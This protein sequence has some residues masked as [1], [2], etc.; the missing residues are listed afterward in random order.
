MEIV[1]DSLASGFASKNFSINW[2][3]WNLHNLPK[4]SEKPTESPQDYV[5]VQVS[6]PLPK[7]KKWHFEIQK[8][9]QLQNH[10]YHPLFNLLTISASKPFN[11]PHLVTLLTIYP[12]SSPPFKR[13][14]NKNVHIL[15]LYSVRNSTLFFNLTPKFLLIFTFLPLLLFLSLPVNT[16]S[17]LT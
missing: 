15:T 10:V 5:T 7:N 12:P 3:V 8:I 2:D 16:L 14:I 13:L 4:I 1:P 11:P 17:F 9:C 6:Q